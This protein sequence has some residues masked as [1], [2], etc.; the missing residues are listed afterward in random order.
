VRLPCL[1]GALQEPA[2]VLR[3]SLRVGRIIGIGV[4]VVQDAEIGTRFRP[5]VL[6]LGWMD[7]WSVWTVACQYIVISGGISNLLADVDYLPIDISFGRSVHQA[8]DEWRVRV[9]K[10]LLSAGGL[11]G[12]VVGL[13]PIVV[14]QSDDKHMLDMHVIVLALILT[15]GILCAQH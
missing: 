15:L 3:C 9:L 5:D 11:A 7:V 6:R 12:V 1:T 8:V 2:Q 13:G 10:Y 4:I 14:F